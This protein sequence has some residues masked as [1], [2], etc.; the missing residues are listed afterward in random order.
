[1]ALLAQAVVSN[2]LVYCSGFVGTEVVDGQVKLIEGSVKDETQQ[3][4]SHLSKVLEAAGSSIRDII[5]A[6]VYLIDF[7]RDFTEMNQVW[8]EVKPPARTTIGV[9]TLPVGSRVEIDCIAEVS[10][11]S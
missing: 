2:G 8:L 10:V 7:E 3:T 9:A 5:Q 6:K 1:M 11:K 4:L